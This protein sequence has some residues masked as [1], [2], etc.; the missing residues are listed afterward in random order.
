MRFLPRV[1]DPHFVKGCKYLD[2]AQPLR[3]KNEREKVMYWLNKS[4]AEFD[5]SK[6]GIAVTEIGPIAL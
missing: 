4:Q 1:S 2:I 3:K 6:V 5:K